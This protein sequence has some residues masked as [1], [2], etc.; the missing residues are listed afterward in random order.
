MRLGIPAA[1]DLMGTYHQS[2]IG[3]LQDTDRAWA[4]WQLAADMGSPGAMAFLGDKLIGTRDEPRLG[5]WG[6]RPVG[7]PMLR[8]AVAQGNGDAARKLG[9]DLRID[10]KYEEAL[11]TFQAGVRF[12]GALCAGALF[13]YFDTGDPVVGGNKDRS[14]AMRYLV[15]SDALEFDPDLRLPNLDKVLP[16]PPAPLPTWDGDKNTLIDAAKGLVPTPGPVAPPASAASQRTGRAH[17]PEGHALPDHPEHPQPPAYETT[18]ASLAG[19]W[20]AQLL[21][22]T[23]EG[24]RRW[25]EEQIPLRYERGEPFARSRAGLT[26]DDG[27]ILFHYL[28]I[29]VA[30]AKPERSED[31]RVAQ[32]IARY[33]DVPRPIVS[34]SGDK[35]A[36]HSGVWLGRIPNEHPAATLFNH[37]LRQT[38]VARGDAFP[39][40]RTL[41]L[42]VAPSIVTWHWWGEANVVRGDSCYV[43]VGDKVCDPWA[44][45]RM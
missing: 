15:L 13:S 33:A 3:V 20:L 18:S 27:R 1:F 10:E 41:H 7:L 6:N 25:N 24:H 38:Y 44:T 19:Y 4:F 39:D 11:A 26:D 22:P 21:N 14:R 42:D 36:T 32:R 17:I 34:V 23:T 8:C 35:T 12:G 31:P 45:P 37:W 30:L 5:F 16:L 9:G 28:G 29:P 40:P 2:G 43:R